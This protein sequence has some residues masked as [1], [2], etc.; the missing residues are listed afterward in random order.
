MYYTTGLGKVSTITLAVNGGVG[1]IKKIRRG[2]QSPAFS[3]CF[4]IIAFEYASNA[5]LEKSER[6]PSTSP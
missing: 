6:Y 1:S 2:S 4:L 3:L 5:R